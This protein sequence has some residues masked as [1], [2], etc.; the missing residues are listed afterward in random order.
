MCVVGHVI[1]LSG[2]LAVALYT[3]LVSDMV[4][5]SVQGEPLVC[6]GCGGAGGVKCFACSGTGAM[7]AAPE[8]EGSDPVSRAEMIRRAR[9]V[10]P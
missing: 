8:D 2:S 3:R 4:C 7:G 1:C 9:K 10:Q 6:E 5:V